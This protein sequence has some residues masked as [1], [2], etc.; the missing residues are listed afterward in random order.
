MEFKILLSNGSIKQIEILSNKRELNRIRN[1]DQHRRPLCGGLVPPEWGFLYLL[2]AWAVRGARLAR[3]QYK[4]IKM[5]TTETQF[6]APNK[7]F[8]TSSQLSR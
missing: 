1:R 3:P 5:F 7:S 8:V 4:R 2:P 6:L